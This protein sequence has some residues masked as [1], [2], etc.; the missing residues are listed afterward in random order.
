MVPA[1]RFF[2][3]RELMMFKRMRSLILED[4]KRMPSGEIVAARA[5]FVI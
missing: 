4:W 5:R 2:A 1:D 3:Y